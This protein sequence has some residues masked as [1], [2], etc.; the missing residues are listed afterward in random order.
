MRTFK[1]LHTLPLGNDPGVVRSLCFNH[2]G[3]IV[4]A[5]E[6]GWVRLFDVNT[7]ASI[8]NWQASEDAL[9]T[10]VRFSADQNS[11]YTLSDDGMFCEWSLHDSAR[12]LT[13]HNLSQFCASPQNLMTRHE[14]A[15]HS[16]P[17]AVSRK[18]QLLC[19]SNT[20]DAPLLAAGEDT[21][22]D[23]TQEIEVLSGE[24]SYGSITSVDWH[25]SNPI[26]TTGTFSGAICISELAVQLP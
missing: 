24:S 7:R 1:Q 8:L 12:C 4:A 21:Q 17:S 23:T 16:P 3:K 22:D 20:C 25:P 26:C 13:Y 19:T 14:F 5:A 10:A 9:V 15:L 6:D 2:N 18:E 11:V